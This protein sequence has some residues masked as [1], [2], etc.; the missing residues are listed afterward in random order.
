MGMIPDFLPELQ[1]YQ[2]ILLNTVEGKPGR[3][4]LQK[5]NISPETAYKWHLGYCPEN[6]DPQCYYS[7]TKLNITFFWRR[8][9]NRL[10]IPIFD[11]NGKL[12]S[13]SG[14]SIDN[15]WPK[16][17][18]YP[19]PASHTLFGL[20][21]NKDD[22]RDDNFAVVTEGQL[23]VISAWQNS[24]K[25]VVCSFGA[26]ASQEHLALLSRYTSNIYIVYDNDNAGKRGTELL[27]KIKHMDLNIIFCG[28]VFNA[29]E[30][31]DNWIQTHTKEEFINKL[32]NNRIQQLRNK[33][34]QLK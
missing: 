24:I 9:N 20:N 34:K 27:K 26:H 17:N 16:Y 5:R 32:K 25:T 1:E 29:G 31:L 11:S 3:E 7:F 33:L 14:R 22:I 12:I 8:M 23:D 18:H 28:E 15:K 2:Y 10:I 13:L 6:Y 4:Y 30:D 21:I 19:F